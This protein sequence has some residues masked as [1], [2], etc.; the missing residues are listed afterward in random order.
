MFRVA[1]TCRPPKLSRAAWVDDGALPMPELR[2]PSCQTLNCLPGFSPFRVARCGNSGCRAQLPEPRY[3]RAMRALYLAR[4]SIAKLAVALGVVSLV[5]FYAA[6]ETTTSSGGTRTATPKSAVPP[7]LPVF[8][9]GNMRDPAHGIYRVIDRSPRE[10]PLEIRT[11]VGRDYLIK[12]HNV[13]TEAPALLFFVHGGTP[14][15]VEVPFGRYR[16]IYASGGKWCDDV[17]LFGPD[18]SYREA[19]RDLIFE[20]MPYSNTIKGHMVTLIPLRYGNLPTRSIGAVEFR[21][22]L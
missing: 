19:D 17:T 7:S 4:G 6:Q 5:V 1:Q 2:C 15:N 16:L 3:V 21:K 12:L 18:T 20:E 11:S 9:C 10:A 14:L 13:E 22:G 8:D